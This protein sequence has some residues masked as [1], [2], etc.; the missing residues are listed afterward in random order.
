MDYL[1]AFYIYQRRQRLLVAE[2]LHCYIISIQE[3]ENAIHENELIHFLHDCYTK[4]VNKMMQLKVGESA[5]GRITKKSKHYERYRGLI[6]LITEHRINPFTFFS[7]V[8]QA[9][10]AR[11]IPCTISNVAT[12]KSI[13]HFLC[14][15]RSN[16]YQVSTYSR[17]QEY[18]DTLKNQLHTDLFSLATYLL[19]KP[20]VVVSVCEDFLFSTPTKVMLSLSGQPITLNDAEHLFYEDLMFCSDFRSRLTKAWNQYLGEQINKI[21]SMHHEL[22][23]TN[24]LNKLQEIITLLQVLKLV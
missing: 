14:F 9:R 8:V 15:Q 7:F 12:K 11:H 1:T 16:S 22:R 2:Q 20:R 23:D 24:F 17:H 10:R 3:Q 13:E 5:V 19:R 21:Q 18:E 4:A 6:P